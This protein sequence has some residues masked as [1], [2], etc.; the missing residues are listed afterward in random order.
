MSPATRAHH[1]L[2]TLL[3]GTSVVHAIS[4][5][6]RLGISDLLERGPQNA[7]TLARATG[8]HPESLYRLLRALTAAGVYD[9]RRKRFSLTPLSDL[10][11][12][13]AGDS[14]RSVAALA[15]GPWR[16]AGFGLLYS[17]RTGRPAFE[18]EFGIGFYDYLS[19]NPRERGLFAEVM[20]YHWRT[21][22]P[23]ILESYAFD[24]AHTIVDVGGGSG[25]M[26]GAILRANPN[27]RGV[28]VETEAMASQARRRIRAA[29]LATR[30]EVSSR[31]F[32]RPLPRGGDL[33]VLAFVLHNWGDKQAVAILHGCRRAMAPGGRVLIIETPLTGGSPFAAIHDLEM[34]LYMR[35]GKERTLAEYRRLL[36]SAGLSFCRRIPTETPASLIEARAG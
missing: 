17:V 33:Y 21:A 20:E 25:A 36:E 8:T 10:L 24:R 6:A 5:A 28:L 30:C 27:V 16:R 13:N 35:G 1:A 23:A 34:L 7:R 19:A 22:G 32:F 15:G 14:M 9:E 11:R 18:R 31:G 12:S 29:R 2:V 26:L 4:V 3:S